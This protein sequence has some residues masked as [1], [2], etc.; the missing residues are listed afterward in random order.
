MYHSRSHKRATIS[1]TSI[2]KAVPR[3]I[4][5]SNAAKFTS[6]IICQTN[7]NIFA[8]IDPEL[9]TLILTYSMHPNLALIL[10]YEKNKAQNR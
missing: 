5:Q 8:S 9:H 4:S 10:I 7:Y 6:I 1:Q 2:G 3:I